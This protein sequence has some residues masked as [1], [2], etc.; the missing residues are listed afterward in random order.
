MSEMMTLQTRK[1]LEISIIMFATNSYI[2][3]ALR[4]KNELVWRYLLMTFGPSVRESSSLNVIVCLYQASIYQVL[5]SLKAL[6]NA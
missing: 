6:Y 5:S 1:Y 3:N 4:Y 2:D